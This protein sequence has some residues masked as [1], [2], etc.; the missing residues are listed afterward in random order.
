M[1]LK[2]QTKDQLVALAQ[3]LQQQIADLEAAN[4]L[5]ASDQSAESAPAAS[6][7]P[8][9]M[10]MTGFLRACVPAKRKNGTIVDGLFKF[11]VET[12]VSYTD[13]T[14]DDGAYIWKRVSDY[15]TA[16]FT[17]DQA[18]ADQLLFLL[19]TNDWTIVRNWYRYATNAKNRVAST[20]PLPEPSKATA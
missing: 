4:E 13:G 9:D 7:I 6:D 8:A 17:C 15:K 1:S 5:L 14:D 10:M 12:S 19:E 20:E 11:A 2:S 3:S 18:L 16:W